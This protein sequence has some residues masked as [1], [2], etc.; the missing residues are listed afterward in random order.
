MIMFPPSDVD[1]PAAEVSP[2]CWTSQQ[3]GL[4]SYEVHEGIQIRMH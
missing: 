1:L 2:K 3:E 4:F